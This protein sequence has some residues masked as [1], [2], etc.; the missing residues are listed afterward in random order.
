VCVLLSSYQCRNKKYCLAG[1]GVFEQMKILMTVNMS[2][3]NTEAY[4][5]REMLPSERS[6]DELREERTCITII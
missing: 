1:R 5:I 4:D 6:V 3:L 2:L